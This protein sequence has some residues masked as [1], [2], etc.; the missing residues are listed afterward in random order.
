[1]KT[2]QKIR[3]RHEKGVVKV[4]VLRPDGSVLQTP[5][6]DSLTGLTYRPDCT[7]NPIPDKPT[8]AQIDVAK[9]LIDYVAQGFPFAKSEHFSTWLAGVIT[10]FARHA[11]QGPSPLF[12]VDANARGTGKS[13]LVDIA[14]VLLTGDI[15]PRWSEL[16]KKDGA[17]ASRITLLASLGAPFLLIDNCTKPIGNRV[18]DSMLTAANCE[19]RSPA[20]NAAS[21]HPLM[22]VTWMTANNAQ[23]AKGADTARRT[24][25]C[26][27]ETNLESSEL[28]RDFAEPDI[29]A[30]TSKQRR[31]LVS[32]VLTL[33]RAFFVHSESPPQLAPWGSYTDWSRV[34]RGCLVWHGYEDV[35]RWEVRL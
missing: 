21:T 31:N 33:L 10:P 5:G 30:W 3:A 25:W 13:T 34:V 17:E 15:A 6:Y 1:M 11:F 14:H 12:L 24:A 27:L 35:A 28:R 4:P 8:R 19:E 20:T 7:F 22:F 29:L 32:S 26:R 9:G 18:L 2:K 16:H 23:K